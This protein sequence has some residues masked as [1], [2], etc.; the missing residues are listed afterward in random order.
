MLRAVYL[1]RHGETDWNASGR[2]QGHT[3]VALN[4]NGRAQ[5]LRVAEALRELAVAG[6]V[7]SDLARAHETGRIVAEELTVPLVYVDEALRERSFG[8]FEGLTRS[9]CELRYAEAWALWLAER[10]PPPGGEDQATLAKRVTRAIVT[11]AERVATDSAGAVIVSHA[12]AIRAFVGAQTGGP[13]PPPVANGEVWRATWD[14]QAFAIEGKWNPTAAQGPR[15]L[16]KS[17]TPPVV[18]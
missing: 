7:A 16:T 2:W 6:V 17:R 10:R 13:L 5:A 1:V 8:C 15:E 4:A 14:G 12:A 18:Q 3:D 9:E 11:A